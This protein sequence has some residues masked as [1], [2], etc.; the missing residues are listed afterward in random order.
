[1]HL[2]RQMQQPARLGARPCILLGQIVGACA[3]QVQAQMHKHRG[4]RTA[5]QQ[6]GVVTAAVRLRQLARLWAQQ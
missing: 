4:S 6:C 5:A 3:V 2:F 1:M